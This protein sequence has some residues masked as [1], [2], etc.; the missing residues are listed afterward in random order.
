MAATFSPHPDPAQRPQRPPLQGILRSGAAPTARHTS[1]SQVGDQLVN[2][3]ATPPP[4]PALPVD[5]VTPTA[6][7]VIHA[8][9][10]GE[11]QSDPFDLI[12]NNDYNTES[13]YHLSFSFT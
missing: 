5:D 4:P 1:D 13:D 10:E 7:Q 6:I 8:Q 12:N 11:D 3:P 2:T 9:K